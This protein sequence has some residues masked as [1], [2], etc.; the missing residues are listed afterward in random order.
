MQVKH[1]GKLSKKTI[2]ETAMALFLIHQFVD[3]KVFKK[4]FGETSS[5]AAWDNMEKYYDGDDKVKMVNLKSLR[6]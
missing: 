6:R 2:I 1:K 5:K 3:S 4:I